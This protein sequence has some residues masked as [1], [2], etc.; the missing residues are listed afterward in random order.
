MTFDAT[1]KPE[2]F[3]VLFI[4]PHSFLNIALWIVIKVKLSVACDHQSIARLSATGGVQIHIF[5]TSYLIRSTHG[6]L[7]QDQ[8]ETNQE[9][10]KDFTFCTVFNLRG[11]HPHWSRTVS[12][13]CLVVQFSIG[14]SF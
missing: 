4:S 13:N 10:I 6:N 2:P 5:N 7:K 9:S 14:S 11:K 3:L 8:F 1:W 12:I